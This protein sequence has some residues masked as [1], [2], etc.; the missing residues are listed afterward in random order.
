M[1]RVSVLL[2]GIALISLAS[3]NVVAQSADDRWSGA[4]AAVFAGKLG[5]PEDDRDDRFLFDTNLDGSFNDSVF[6]AAGADAFSPGYCS[7][8]ANGPMASAGCN[9]NDDGDEWG[10]RAGYDWQL[11]NW[12]YGFS[13]EYASTDVTDVV[14]SFSTT[15]AFYTMS[16]ELDNVASIRG[17]L[18]YT[19]GA[20]SSNLVYATAGVVRADITNVYT[21]S[22]GV[23]TFTN[24]GDHS[25]YGHQFGI[26][27]ERWLTDRITLSVEYLVT[28]VE[29]NDYRVR[30]SGPAPATNPFILVNAA[31]TDFRR[32]DTEFEVDSIRLVAS[33]RF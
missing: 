2:T 7:G 5:E 30:A 4:Y 3:A 31:G 10:L 33:F 21:T 14:T 8:I 24:N 18:G 1:K 6:T 15:P 28:S 12:V 29:D 9:L 32:S 22:N 11:R 20:D 25:G 19:F 26:G 16:R 13:G 23:N 17:R 27:F